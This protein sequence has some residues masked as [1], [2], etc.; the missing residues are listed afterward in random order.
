MTVNDDTSFIAMISTV[1]VASILILYINITNQWSALGI[2]E[3]G[4]CF[5][6]TWLGG[7]IISLYFWLTESE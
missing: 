4:M 5:L 6:I 2:M 1:L 7:F 3:I